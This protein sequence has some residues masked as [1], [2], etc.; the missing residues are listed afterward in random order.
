MKKD[1]L[2]NIIIND[3]KEVEQLM[4]AFRGED[5]VNPAFVNLAKTK[6]KSIED[7][8]S[9]LNEVFGTTGAEKLSKGIKEEPVPV[10]EESVQPEKKKEKVVEEVIEKPVVEIKKEDAGIAEVKEPEK[11]VIKEEEKKKPEPVKEPVAAKPEV[12]DNKS[13]G[14][15]SVDENARLGDVL[16]KDKSALNERV[17]RKNSENEI[18]FT[19]PVKD[20][21]KAMGINDRF[22]YQRELFNGNADLF[23]Q[24]LDQINSMNSFDDAKNF[25]N[26]NFNWDK[27]SDT[28]ETFFKI[29]KRRFL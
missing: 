12:K 22:F 23:N 2:L 13:P 26:S 8:L 3:L 21:R 29:V 10:K 24:T 28:T 7:E 14:K 11:E 9:L 1:A 4:E 19:K 5:N 20:V 18:I 16:Q 17:T 25:L 6:I 15:K 27:E